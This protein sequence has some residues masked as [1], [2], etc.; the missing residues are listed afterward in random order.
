[1][2]LTNSVFPPPSAPPERIRNFVV[3]STGQCVSSIGSWMQKTGIGWLAWELTHSVAWVGTIALADL[4][5]ALWVAPLAGVV[6]DRSNPYRLTWITQILMLML[7]LGMYFLVSFGGLNIWLLL[8]F[9]VADATLQGFAQ[10]VRMAVTG[11]LGG[12]T[13]ISQAI[14]TNSIAVNLARS[15]GPAIAGLIMVGSGVAPVFAC[16]AL[17]FL[18]MLAAIVY[19][20]PW[21]DHPPR[22]DERAPLR[23]DISA[24]FRYVLRTPE[25]SNFFVLVL[26]F[27]VLVRPFTELLPAFAGDVFRG[28]PQTLASLMSA[29]GIG[30]LVGAAFML[31]RGNQAALVRILLVSGGVL[32]LALIAFTSTRDI[33]WALPA[34]TLAGLCHVVCN[35]SMQ[36]MG[37]LLADPGYRGRVLSLYSLLFRACPSV[38]AFLIGLAADVVSLQ[39]LVGSA[40]ALYGIMLFGYAPIARRLYAASFRRREVADQPG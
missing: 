11:T 35:I 16:N 27:S 25:I 21:I 3:F 12:K 28:G 33:A 30:A 36:S 31:R 7:A 2:S 20:R 37:Q 6:A 17:S 22:H 40:A 23:D 10:P 19:V 13:R 26:A 9:A 29:Q 32:A 1:M 14:A 4:I 8:A 39:V 24:G 5:A 38:G 15:I 18:A 34:M